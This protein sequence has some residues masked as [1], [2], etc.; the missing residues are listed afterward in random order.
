MLDNMPRHVLGLER[1]EV[2]VTNVVKCRLPNNRNP[3][4]DEIAVLAG[5]KGADSPTEA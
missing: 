1:G 5:A 3:E 2:F 4:P